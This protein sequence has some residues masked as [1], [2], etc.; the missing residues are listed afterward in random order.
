MRI[1]SPPDSGYPGIALRQLE[2]ADIPAWFDYLSIPEVVEHTSWNL[3]SAADLVPML[4]ACESSTPTS[5]RRM[6][7][8]DQEHGDLVGT[9]GFHTVSDVNR[10]AE[11]AYDLAPAYWGRG[12]ASAVCA[13]VTAWAFSREDLVRV[14][15]TVLETNQRSDKVLKN[16]AY[17]YEGLLRAY[18]MVRGTP[19]NFRM[20]ARVSESV[21]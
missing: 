9:I 10:S 12:I 1:D 20:Y 13:A 11:I 7:M 2:R 14:Q 15:A 19:G 6:A 3:H 5:I 21:G 17:R 16:C 8:I 4:D 18:R